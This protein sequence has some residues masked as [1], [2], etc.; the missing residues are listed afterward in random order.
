MPAAK[1]I[2]GYRGVASNQ[3]DGVDIEAFKPPVSPTDALYHLTHLLFFHLHFLIFNYELYVKRAKCHELANYVLH[4]DSPLHFFF[5]SQ[6]PWQN[7]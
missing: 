2:D 5:L 4:R 7:R 6:C 3:K 1:A